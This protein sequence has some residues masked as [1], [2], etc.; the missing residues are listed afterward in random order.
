MQQCGQIYEVNRILL[1]LLQLDSQH[2]R[3]ASCPFV[4]LRR[5]W[6]A[7]STQRMTA[8]MHDKYDSE[9]RHTA[10]TLCG[11]GGSEWLSRS[12]SIER[13]AV[14]LTTLP[15]A[16]SVA[17]ASRRL[18]R[19]NGV[20]TATVNP[21]TDSAVVTFDAAAVGVETVM[22]AIIDGAGLSTNTTPVRWHQSARGTTCP[23]CIERI[24]HAVREVIGVHDVRVSA[25][26]D[27]LTV[28]YTPQL[29]DVD[30]VRR[31]IRLAMLEVAHGGC[32]GDGMQVCAESGVAK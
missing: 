24:Q 29:T 21:I 2:E 18:G 25:A 16:A 26:T 27:T 12:P 6:R 20:I 14:G 5:K 32:D 22:A 19:L 9:H 23:R 1:W 7:A 30:A 10:C 31:A 13:L 15:C 3:C 8:I 4:Q 17:Q 28:K 11:G